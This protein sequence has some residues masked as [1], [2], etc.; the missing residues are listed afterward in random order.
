[1][2]PAELEECQGVKRTWLLGGA[3]AVAVGMTL[4]GVAYQPVHAQGQPGIRVAVIDVGKVFKEYSKY[5]SLADTLKADI[6]AK[7]NELKSMEQAMRGKAESI[8][9]IKAQADRDRIEKEIADLKFSFEKKRQTY[10]SD[11]MRREADMYT[12][13]YK[14]LT[15]M[16]AAYCKENSI[17]MVL[18]LQEDGEDPQ[19]VLQTINRQ[20]VY[21]H[22][23][24]D[25]T[26]V[27]V[28]GLN[29]RMTAK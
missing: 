18:R 25:L 7:E 13:I 17:H 16:L 22:P 27:M 9:S 21:C 26:T 1:V 3:L 8:K 24:L 19:A 23:N 10:R 6:E 5:K 2:L 20:V 4:C 14:E 29:S 28:Q 15:D 12:T 11:L